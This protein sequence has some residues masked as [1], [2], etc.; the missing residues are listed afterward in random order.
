M[1]AAM[2]AYEYRDNII[3]FDSGTYSGPR[4]TGDVVVSSSKS[5][6]RDCTVPETSKLTWAA[7]EAVL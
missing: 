7:V 3:W 6:L 5:M 4:G 2:D 1:E